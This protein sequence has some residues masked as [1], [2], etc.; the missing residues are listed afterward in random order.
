MYDMYILNIGICRNTNQSVMIKIQL[1]TMTDKQLIRYFPRVAQ[2]MDKFEIL[3]IQ[4]L[5]KYR[6]FD[7][8]R[9]MIQQRR[10]KFIVTRVL[11]VIPNRKRSILDGVK[12]QVH[13][14]ICRYL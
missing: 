7:S 3:F 13:C 8:M 2:G 1:T 10:K 6:T 4:Y 9:H 11:N 12:G 5:I 14:N